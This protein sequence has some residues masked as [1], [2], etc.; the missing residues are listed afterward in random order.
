MFDPAEGM[1]LG[2][3]SKV[4]DVAG[5]D[6]VLG[7]PAGCIC[8]V[9]SVETP[10]EPLK[11]MLE[12]LC[13]DDVDEVGVVVETGAIGLIGTP[14]VLS[15]VVPEET[16]ADGVNCKD[17]SLADADSRDPNADVMILLS[18]AELGLAPVS[19][20]VLTSGTGVPTEVEGSVLVGESEAILGTADVG[21]VTLVP[22][23]LEGNPGLVVTDFVLPGVGEDTI[24]VAP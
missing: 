17:V 16:E 2:L 19:V 4:L 7:V 15:E 12:L 18:A 3:V 1:L 23:V 6:L 10:T 8:L 21:E 14:F 20:V 13:A 5:G 9:D 11:T 22:D 24:E